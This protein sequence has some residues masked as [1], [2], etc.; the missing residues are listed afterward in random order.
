VLAEEAFRLYEAFRPGVPAGE[1]GWG[2][3]GKLS[4]KKIEDLAE[5]TR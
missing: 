3:K 2:A 4:F 5:R 1:R